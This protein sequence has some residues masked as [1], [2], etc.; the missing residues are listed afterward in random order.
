[1]NGILKNDILISAIIAWFIAQLIKLI[2][3]IL[4]HKKFDMSLL[5][6]SGGMPSSHTSL[7]VSMAT[8]IGIIEG[9]SST[10]FAIAAVF[11]M[12]VMYDAMGVRRQAGKHAQ[13][14]NILILNN[15]AQNI[16][17][18]GKLKELVGHRPIEV[19]FGMVLGI[20]VAF[21]F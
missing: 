20:T 11:C 17:D 10:F 12:V 8:K 6:S 4:H 13:I 7:T 19:F 16:K 3:S 14:L 1:M 2:I 5:V 18:F 15:L 21:L 9:F